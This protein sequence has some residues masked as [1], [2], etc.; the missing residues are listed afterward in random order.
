MLVGVLDG[1]PGHRRRVPAVR[2]RRGAETA[3][4]K[5]IWTDGGHRRQ[6]VRAGASRRAGERDRRGRIPSRLPDHRR[7]SARGRGAVPG[8]R[9]P[10]AGRAAARPRARSTRWRSP[11]T[12]HDRT[13]ARGRRTRGLRLASRGVAAH[14]R[15]PVGPVRS[16]LGRAGAHG[17]A[18]PAGLRHV[19]RRPDAA[20]PPQARD[21]CPLAGRAA[22]RG[23]RRGAGGPRD[24]A[25]R[26]GARRDRHAHRAV[27]RVEGDRHAGLRLPRQG[28]LAAEG[29]RH[30]PRG[31]AVRQARHR[32]RGPVRRGGRRG[33]RRAPA[34]DSWDDEPSRDR[35]YVDRVALVRARSRRPPQGQPVVAALAHA[36]PIYEF[37]S[38]S[39]DLVFITPADDDSLRTILASS[40][41]SA[42]PM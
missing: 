23:A 35:H 31:G 40:P 37:A 6:G 4:L 11:R 28:G 2:G 8:H 16:V 10:P 12:C 3:E 36:R 17:R 39:A 38:R 24:D 5:R 21:R 30:R 9:I 25:H 33:R 41:T 20:A 19:R 7:P 26:S 42:E 27:P 34:W 13:P 29:Q 14:P 18:R 32:G 22:R 1:R 15:T